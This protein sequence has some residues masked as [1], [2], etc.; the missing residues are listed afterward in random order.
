MK[1]VQFDAGFAGSDLI[2]VHHYHVLLTNVL[3]VHVFSDSVLCFRDCCHVL[4]YTD[5][6]DKALQV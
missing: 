3:Y 5:C 1:G 2:S 4:V 6:F